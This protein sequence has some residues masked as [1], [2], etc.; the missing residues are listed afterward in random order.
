[1]TPTRII[2]GVAAAFTL[3]G[4]AAHAQ[5]A[6]TP[7][8]ASPAEGAVNP[9]AATAPAA[10]DRSAAPMAPMAAEAAPAPMAAP[11]A[12]AMGADVST[13]VSSSATP[14]A[15]TVTVTTLTNGPVP[16]TAENRAKYGSPMSRVG[17][18]TRAAGN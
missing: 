5:D 4:A 11:S 18:M 2:L 6:M 15:G 17:K 13:T 9:P 3:A 10:E 8:P 7:P 12:A 16:D 1:M 14:V